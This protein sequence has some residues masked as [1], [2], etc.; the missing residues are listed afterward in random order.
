[1]DGLYRLTALPPPRQTITDRRYVWLT[2]RNTMLE[3]VYGEKRKTNKLAQR[4]T[5]QLKNLVTE[6]PAKIALREYAKVSN[7]PAMPW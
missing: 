2:H 4:I 3:D 7:A 1:M 5:N 6:K